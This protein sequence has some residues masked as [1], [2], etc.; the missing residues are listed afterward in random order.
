MHA[1]MRATNAATWAVLAATFLAASC[2]SSNPAGPSAGTSTGAL[3]AALRQQGATVASGNTLSP[4]PCLSASGQTILVN[5]R[6]VNVFEYP[7]AAAAERDAA[8][9]SPDG[10]AVSNGRCA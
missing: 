6:V 1:G 2:G 4:L 7:S 10:S 3:L 9:I 5:T 8:K